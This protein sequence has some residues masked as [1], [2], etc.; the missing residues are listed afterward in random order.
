M[1]SVFNG[2]LMNDC[3]VNGRQKLA[4]SSSLITSMTVLSYSPWLVPTMVSSLERL[5]RERLSR[6]LLSLI[7]IIA[8]GHLAVMLEVSYMHNSGTR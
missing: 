6:D 8:S 3:N 2:D 1:N 7:T 5:S 4:F